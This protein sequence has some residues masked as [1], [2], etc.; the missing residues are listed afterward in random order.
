MLPAP[1]PTLPSSSTA[2]S[3]LTPPQFKFTRFPQVPKELQLQIWKATLPGPR[4]VKLRYT[5]VGKDARCT[6]TSRLEART[7]LRYCRALLTSSIYLGRARIPVALHVC[8]DSRQVARKFY[9]PS[10]GLEG[11]SQQGSRWRVEPKVY[12]DFERDV[13]FLD[14]EGCRPCE[15]LSGMSA[16]M[17]AAEAKR[18]HGLTEQVKDLGKVRHLVAWEYLPMVA[19]YWG[20]KNPWKGFKG[21]EGKVGG[22]RWSGGGWER[23]LRVE[24]RGAEEDWGTLEL[25]QGLEF[26]SGLK[27]EIVQLT[28]GDL[29]LMSI[30]S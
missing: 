9:R 17:L 30:G 7:T 14:A 2:T 16:E 28:A 11:R 22:V 4:V 23:D 18:F 5:G 12:F 1:P 6:S 19:V 27:W 13:L 8:T 21:L 20:D 24:K 15:G 25:E 26:L 3:Q 29:G 10:F